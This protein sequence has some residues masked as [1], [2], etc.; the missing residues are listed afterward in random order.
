MKAFT[1]VAIASLVAVGASAQALEPRAT[2]APLEQRQAGNPAVN[3]LLNQYSGLLTVPAFQS[4]VA[5]VTGDP[6]FQSALAAAATSN[7]APLESYASGLQSNKELSSL[8]VSA[9]GSSSAAAL[10]SKA[11]S[12]A[13]SVGSSASKSG[14]SSA[15]AASASS[16]KAAN[17][18]FG[19]VQAPLA[20]VVTLVGAAA[21]AL[22]A[23]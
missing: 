16:S 6:A 23:I 1:A 13:S 3:S 9:L 8:A 4:V 7:Y 22:A 19:G 17:G 12:V 14:S 20:A 11:S 18:A 5:S 10:Y 15:S 2:A 21:V